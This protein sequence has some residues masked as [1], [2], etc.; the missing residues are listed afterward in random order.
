MHGTKIRKIVLVFGDA[1]GSGFG[2]TWERDNGTIRYRY[3]L[4]GEDMKYSSSNLRKVL[5]LVDTLEKHV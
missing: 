4:W 3:C 1:S 5:N 2:S